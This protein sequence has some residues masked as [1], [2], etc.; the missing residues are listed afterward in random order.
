M[1]GYVTALRRVSGFIKTAPPIVGCLFIIL[2]LHMCS[3][4]RLFASYPASVCPSLDVLMVLR[5]GVAGL[6]KMLKEK[7]SYMNGGLED[8]DQL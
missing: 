8:T 5:V 7:F 4:P 3:E 6:E 2:Y 1:F